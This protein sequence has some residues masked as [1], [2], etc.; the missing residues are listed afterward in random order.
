M[1]RALLVSHDEFAAN[2]LKSVESILGQMEEAVAIS[3]R[4]CSL[5]TLKEQIAEHLP[6]EG[7]VVIFVDLLG[8]NFTAAKLCGKKNPVICGFNLPMLISF[9]TKRD[10]M[11]LEQLVKTVAADGQRGIRVEYQQ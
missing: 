11:P 6:S 5:Q 7:E 4:G 10:K 2:C 1:V 9:F 8:S 3:N